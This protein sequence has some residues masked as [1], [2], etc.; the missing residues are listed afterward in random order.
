[1]S[2]TGIVWV[3]DTSSICQIRRQFQNTVKP[4]VFERLTELVSEER[5]VFPPEVIGEL[6][7]GAEDRKRPDAQLAWAKLNEDVACAELT[8]SFEEI[9][10]VLAEVPTVLDPDKDSGAEEADPYVLAVALRLRANGV[11]ARIVTEE[12]TDTPTKM[13]LNTAAG[14][15]GIPSL[16]LGGFIVKE[17]IV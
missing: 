11:D 1:M 3:I 6:E 16:P 2:P 17:R 13:S 15:L 9:R 14:L 8:C 4:R 7:R 5:L 10:D 12:R